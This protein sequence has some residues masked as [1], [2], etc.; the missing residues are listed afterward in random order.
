MTDPKRQRR[1]QAYE[2]VGELVSIFLRGSTWWANWQ[3]NDSQHRKTLKTKSL[4]EA[5]LRAVRL[6]AELLSG[7]HQQK[8]KAAGLEEVITEY[9]RHLETERRRPKT[10]T[11]YR[12]IFKHL[13]RIAEDQGVRSVDRITISFLDKYRHA[14]VVAGVCISTVCNECVV[15]RQLVNFARSRDLLSGDPLRGLKIKEPKPAPQPC[16]SREE[17]ARILEASQEPQRSIFTVLADTGARIGEIEWLTWDDVDFRRNVLHIR[18]K[19]DWI[20]KTGDQ[21]AIPMTDRVARLLKSR[22]RQHRWVF[23]AGASKKYPQGG[24]R[25]S[26]RRL[27]CSLKR[28]LKRLGLAGHLHTFR[29]AFISHA[30]S[31]GVPEAV[32]RSIVGHVDASII[33]LYTHIADKRLQEA[34]KNLDGQPDGPV[35]EHEVDDAGQG[36]SMPADSKDKE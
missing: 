25:I 15:I 32:V 23:T 36:S 24:H 8:I 4:K 7:V 11:K 33:R 31:T 18:P 35:A 28:L 3:Q 26:E 34:V 5:R 21:R 9:D 22:P 30:L 12:G 27:L 17:V 10:L 13:R 19:D 29:H 1:S 6:E 2:P 16:F 20:P 14:R